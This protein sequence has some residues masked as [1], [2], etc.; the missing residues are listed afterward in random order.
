MRR[1][2][3]TLAFLSFAVL[4]GCSS[5]PAP[6]GAAPSQQAE[7][8]GGDEGDDADGDIGG[9]VAPNDDPAL[10]GDLG[11]DADVEDADGGPA[12]TFSTLSANG[13]SPGGFYC[14]GDKIGGNPNILYRCRA[15]AS[16]VVVQKCT[17]GCRVHP[18]SDDSCIIPPRA[19]VASPVPG[20]VVTYAYGVRNPRYAA[21]FHTGQ[22]YAT[23]TGS[24]A[25][26]VRSGTV[27]WSNDAGGAYGKWIGLDADNG[28]TY[29]YCHL[30][31]RL[32]A[33]G[34]KVSAGQVIA[35]TGATGNVTGP[36]LHL[37]DHPRGPFVYASVRKPSW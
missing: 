37:E 30:S 24:K 4:A 19:H 33:A 22:D 6:P 7:S 32:V 10:G 17:S 12:P 1:I 13:C 29:V 31:S 20:K 18:G 8:N 3:L 16:P 21:G 28:R 23:P 25:V 34:T 5:E 36:H 15:S 26:A 35:R 11:D 27:R 14:G 2:P 9:A